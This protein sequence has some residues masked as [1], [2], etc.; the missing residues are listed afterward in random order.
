[1][2][3][4]TKKKISDSN[5][6]FYL[7]EENK[8]KSSLSAKERGSGKWMKGRSLSVEIREKIKHSMLGKNTRSRTE[9]EKENLRRINLGKKHTIE[10]KNKISLKAKGKNIGEKNG[11]WQGGISYLY[12]EERKGYIYEKWRRE[13]FSKDNYSCK[14]CNQ[15]GGL[16]HAH[17]IENFSSNKELRYE[18][19]NGITFC[20]KCHKLFHKQF[21]A[22]NNSLEQILIFIKQ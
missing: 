22:K 19:S 14:K 7:L 16:L 12:Q 4:E 6:K 3:E 21:K 20:E 2:L 1:M 10:T 13:I 8:K 15:V 5:K 11:A 9:A 18:I 17:H